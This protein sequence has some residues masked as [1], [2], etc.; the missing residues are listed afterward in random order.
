M[1]DARLR[2]KVKSCLRRPGS[3]RPHP[4]G[5]GRLRWAG[6]HGDWVELAV[7]AVAAAGSLTALRML[8]R[9]SRVTGGL[10]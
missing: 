6:D 8:A 4:R 9:R 5:R 3:Y 1:I 7:S 10:W 2:L